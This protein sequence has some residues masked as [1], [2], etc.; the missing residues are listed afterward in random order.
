MTLKYH[1]LVPNMSSPGT[2][3]LIGA[4]SV[5]GGYTRMTLTVVVM[6]VESSGDVR[7][8]IPMMFAVQVSRFVA[9]LISEC[10]DEKM[11]ELRRIPFLHEEP[12]D[13]SVNDTSAPGLDGTY[14]DD[15]IHITYMQL[16]SLSI[17]FFT[18]YGFGT[19]ILFGVILVYHRDALQ[20]N[21]FVKRYG[22][23]VTKMKTE[24]YL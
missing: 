10:Y 14:V 22:F 16:A 23:L 17:A 11:M 5:L 2:Y 3:A 12:Q 6:L 4:G 19:P 1:M 13:S 15:Y 20:S 18:L 8:I 7:I 24:Y 9:G 21:Q